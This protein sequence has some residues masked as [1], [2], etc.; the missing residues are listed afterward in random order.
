MD[1]GGGEEPAPIRLSLEHPLHPVVVLCLLGNYDNDVPLLE[2]KL[3]FVVRLAVVE[4]STSLV[5]VELV[6][7]LEIGRRVI[8][9][10]G[11]C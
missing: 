8:Y 3:I 6:P 11:N 2:T 1:K 4:G 5:P 7:R 9:L 10:K